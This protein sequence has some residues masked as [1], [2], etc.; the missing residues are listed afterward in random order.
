MRQPSLLDLADVP[1]VGDVHV[2]R[3]RH[4]LGAGAWIDIRRGWLSGSDRL[5]DAL[6]TGV[7]WCAERRQMY[8]SVVDVPRL[9]CF[10]DAGEEWP[11]PVLQE[12]RDVL[13]QA[14]RPE[15]GEDFVTAGLLVMGGSC[16]RTW[17]H[18]VPKTER[19]VGPRISVQFRP[20]GVR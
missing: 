3:V 12:C 8:D 20:R 16:Q 9:T 13:S 11:H 14:Y 17:D 18:C 19:P 1:S 4:S 2:D 15:L 6:A 10:Y 7:E 5:F